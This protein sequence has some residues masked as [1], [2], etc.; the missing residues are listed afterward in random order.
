MN[1]DFFGWVKSLFSPQPKSADEDH[2]EHV[3]AESVDPNAPLPDAEAEA[4]AAEAAAIPLTLA[5]KIKAWYARKKMQVYYFFIPPPQM[6]MAQLTTPEIDIDDIDKPTKLKGQMVYIIIIAFFIAAVLWA[7]LAEIDEVVRAE[8][9][10]VPNDN[11]QVVQSRLPGSVVDI[12]VSLGD[13][14]S[15]GDVLFRIED[16]DVVANF[17][18]NEIDRLSAQAAIIRL[19]AEREGLDALEFPAHLMTGAPDIINQEIA[20]F[21]SRRAAKHGEE[22]IL[23]HETESLRRGIL[24]R[25]AEV[26]AA[27]RQ[28][29]NINEELAIIEPLVEQNIEPRYALVSIKSRRDSE[30]SRLE[31]A[32]LTVRR[33]QSDLN[34]QDQRLASLNIRYIADVETQLVEFK[35]RAAQAEARLES[36]KGKVAYADVKAPVDGTVSAVHLKSVGAVV[37][38][39]ALLAEIVPLGEEVTLRARVMTNDISKIAVGQKVRVSLSSF[40]FSRY[41]SLDGIVEQIASNTTQEQNMPPYFVTMVQIPNPIFENS[42]FRPEVTPGMTAV[43]DVVGDKRT[44]LGYI[45]S[46]IKRAQQIVF[47]EN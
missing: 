4:A 25:Q 29:E 41:G 42:G 23:R 11:V 22:E 12:D 24:E 3:E 18:D 8:G 46:P 16:E 26:R 7:A 39:G 9:E 31:L 45:L 37:E 5:G 38:A 27:K 13:R 6:V 34:A 43:I 1:N 36:L 47:R 10:V 14:V 33:L 32:G 2:V 44:V 15:Q 35:T 17:K 40:D 28:L 30:E 20:L 19:E 21:H